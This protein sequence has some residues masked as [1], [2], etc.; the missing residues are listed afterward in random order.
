MINRLIGVL[1]NIQI[2]KHVD[3]KKYTDLFKLTV[4]SK[5]VEKYYLQTALKSHF[6]IMSIKKIH[7]NQYI[8]FNY[9]I[10]N[11]F[12]FVN[13]TKNA[14]ENLLK[15]MNDYRLNHRKAL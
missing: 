15:R 9:L 5:K 4:E 2:Y 7:L 1:K 12:I 3:T 13:N 11:D 10:T 6:I 14:L 8:E